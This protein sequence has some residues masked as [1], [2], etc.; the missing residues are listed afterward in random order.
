M[1]ISVKHA[2]GIAAIALLLLAAAGAAGS[3]PNA[4]VPSNV[5]ALGRVASVRVSGVADAKGLERNVPVPSCAT[6]EGVQWYR[7][8]APHRGPMVAQLVADKDLDA[9]LAAYHI[10][11]SRARSLLCKTTSWSG[12]TWLA[13]YAHADRSYLIGVARR[14]GSS[15]G[16]YELT[17]R[18]AERPPRPPGALLPAGGVWSTIN[19]VLDRS[20]AY[21]VSLTRGTT[22]RLSLT[23]PSRTSCI[24]FR[25]Y[26]AGTSF[27]AGEPAF[28]RECGG[29]A[30]FTPGIDG[31][32][33]YS[34]LVSMSAGDPV[35]HGY[36]L[37]IAPAGA[38]DTAP[39]IKLDNGQVVS[40]A[41]R[42]RSIDTVD[43]YRFAVPHPSQQTRIEFRHKPN[44]AIR[45]LVTDEMG[46]RI[47][48]LKDSTGD[49]VQRLHLPIG[50]YYA[51]VEASTSGRKA[52][53]YRLQVRVRDVTSTS[54]SSNGGRHVES[55]PDTPVPL[56]VQVTSASHG[57]NLVVEFDH[58]DPLVGWHFAA[59]VATKVDPTGDF[60]TA[61]TPPSVGEWRARARFE[62]NAYS[63]TS[64]SHYVR[65]HIV[66]PLE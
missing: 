32:G 44:S 48:S 1:K 55:P 5:Q 39:G 62:G 41:V 8:T 12:R 7:V 30:L 57:G 56:T 40:A 43:L 2:C 3:S 18:S 11:G 63:S 38:D 65:I 26:R 46:K 14:S 33:L 49:E 53:S 36:R 16:D 61:W 23:S 60:T 4:A 37:Q 13:W 51:A 19:P 17:V 25:I 47:A 42:P 27:V 64:H 28:E 52:G 22:Y 29:Y 45:L 58:F 35:T 15:A 34:I 31:G 24:G 21:A 59:A 54:I 10:V 20:D 50:V 9:A 66:E 6:V